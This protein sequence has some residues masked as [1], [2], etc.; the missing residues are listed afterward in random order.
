MSAF[1]DLDEVANRGTGGNSGT[2]EAL[3]IYKSNRVN[4][5]LGVGVVARSTSLWRYAGSPGSG[6]APTTAINPTRSTPGAM[7]QSNPGG[8]RQ[9]WLNSMRGFAS[10][11]G[12]AC[13]Y[14]RLAQIGGLAGNV[15][16]PQAAA[17]SAARYTG[18]VDSI[19][20]RIYIEI[21][22]QIGTTATTVVCNYNNEAGNP[23][24]TEAVAIGGTG[25]R[26][27][28]RWI[29]LPLA[30]GDRGVQAVTSITLGVTTGTAGDIAVII[31]RPLDFLGFSNSAGFDSHAYFTA[32]PGPIEI[33]T[34]ACLAWYW[35]ALVTSMP[36]LNARLFTSER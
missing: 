2:P 16:T 27:V 36:D 5:A 11:A 17:I 18:T 31:G 12:V 32:A 24:V 13:L 33:R 3:Q 6:V 22:T 20:N 7:G 28:D 10:F 25:L 15:A 26:E 19:G 9:K 8:G 30:S 29:E 35:Q 14:D 34:D 21:S 4:G 23:A 1:I